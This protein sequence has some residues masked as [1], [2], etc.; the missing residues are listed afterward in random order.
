MVSSRDDL[1]SQE[2][3]KLCCHLLAFVMVALL[4]AGCT[5]GT[6]APRPTVKR[7]DVEQFARMMEQGDF[8]LLDVRTQKEFESGHIPGAL[9][10]DIGS[11]SFEAE[12]GKLDAERGY[13]V[14]CRSGRRSARACSQMAEAGFGQLIDLAPG[15]NGWE[16]A[17]RAVN[18]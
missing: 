11:P 8:I 1:V 15:F 2:L 16:S 4:V 17:G 10:L 9:N 14:Y 18:R 12:F 5:P 13:L 7:V 6:S 3:R